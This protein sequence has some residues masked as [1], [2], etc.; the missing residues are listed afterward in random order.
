MM[1]RLGAA[2]IAVF[3]A[4][5][6]LIIPAK[7]DT[8]VLET[9]EE[10]LEYLHYDCAYMLRDEFT[11]YYGEELDEVFAT[12]DALYELLKNCG[13][14][15]WT[16]KRNTEK[17]K[18][19]ISETLYRT[20][21]RIAQ[22]WRLEQTAMLSAEER[23]TLEIALQMVEDAQRYAQ[24]PYDLL[25]RLHDSL[26]ERTVYQLKD[27]NAEGMAA[28]DNAVGALK[29]RGAECDGY[30]DAF[31][32]LGT[33]A[34]FQVGYQVGGT[35][36]ELEGHIWNVVFWNGKWYHADLTWDDQDLEERPD[37]VEYAYFMVGGDMFHNHGWLPEYSPHDLA[38]QNDWSCFYY[39]ADE[40]G[41]TYGV[42]LATVQDAAN[43][44]SHHIRNGYTRA[45]VMVDGQHEGKVLSDLIS[46]SGK[47]TIWTTH[48]GSYTLFD[49]LIK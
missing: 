27:E 18:V 13:L 11:F 30:T 44:V 36:G 23:E 40:T 39:T 15:D 21:F 45:H 43:Y 33:L 19:S 8:P 34:G 17:R 16:Q 1:R 2:L 3:L 10:L 42:Y 31:Y 20:G 25:V 4:L 28:Q 7:A 47:W 29:Y 6:G 14:Y 48:I 41:L 35:D 37:M 9:M 38:E 46:A 32:L 49:V 12:P 5:S 26:C 22:A 24:S